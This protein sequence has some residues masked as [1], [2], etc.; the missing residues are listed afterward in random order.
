VRLVGAVMEKE[1]KRAIFGEKKKCA[2]FPLLLV[3]PFFGMKFRTLLV[4]NKVALFAST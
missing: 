2:M 4:V 3:A 1:K